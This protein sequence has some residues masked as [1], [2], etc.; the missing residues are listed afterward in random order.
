MNICMIYNYIDLYIQFTYI[1]IDICIYYVYTLD[2]YI[3]YTIHQSPL[4]YYTVY[5]C[6]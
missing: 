3:E 5:V 4:I 6:P 2:Y 1:Y